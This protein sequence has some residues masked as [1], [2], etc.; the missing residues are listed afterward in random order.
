MSS[1]DLS[2]LSDDDLSEVEEEDEEPRRIVLPSRTTR[3]NRMNDLQGEEKEAD[4]DF[5]NQDF[6]AEVWTSSA[7]CH[8]LPDLHGSFWG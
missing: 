8:P 6:F 4:A 5:W 2:N 1:D 3:G 7:L